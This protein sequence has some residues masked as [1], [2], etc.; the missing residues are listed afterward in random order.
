MERFV[1]ACN[2]ARFK[3]MLAVETDTAERELLRDLLCREQARFQAAEAL[4]AMAR[5]GREPSATSDSHAGP[6]GLRKKLA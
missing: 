2:I 6:P 1:A 3:Q 4:A 5:R